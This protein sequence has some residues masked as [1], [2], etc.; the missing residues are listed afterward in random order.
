MNKGI[1]KEGV[2]GVLKLRWMSL[3]KNYHSNVKN[4]RLDNPVAIEQP[5]VVLESK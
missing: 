5:E 1:I 4:V 3:F 2:L